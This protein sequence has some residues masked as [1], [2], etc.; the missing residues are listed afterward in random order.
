MDLL[1]AQEVKEQLFDGKLNRG[2]VEQRAASVR[3]PVIYAYLV[4]TDMGKARL[5]T[6]MLRAVNMRVFLL[7]NSDILMGKSAYQGI[8]VDRIVGIRA[9][10]TVTGFPALVLDGGTA[11]TYTATD[12][13][14]NILGG[15]ISP[16]LK[17]KLQAMHEHTAALPELTRNNLVK[18][19]SKGKRYD[20]FGRTTED[21]M[22]GAV[23]FEIQAYC[24]RIIEE[25]SDRSRQLLATLKNGEHNGSVKLNTDLKILVTG[26]DR[27]VIESLIVDDG[28]FL[29]RIGNK[30]NNRIKNKLVTIPHAHHS[31]I[32]DVLR[33]HYKQIK[34]GAMENIRQELVGQRVALSTDKMGTIAGVR[35]GNK[36]SLD[37]YHIYF[38]DL[39]RSKVSTEEVVGKSLSLLFGLI[40]HFIPKLD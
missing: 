21:N 30:Q 33:D 22:Y 7:R 39:E 32:H 5:L 38:D 25:W 16:G 37:S 40:S 9:A 4:A 13:N 3:H 11:F 24:C 23:L 6:R 31:A 35:R 36:L 28:T 34:Q 18:L 20:M 8:G 29:R 19:S 10:Q 12:H 26:G 17:S 1:L 15:G 2:T 14:G 27:D